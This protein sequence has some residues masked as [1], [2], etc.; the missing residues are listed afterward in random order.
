MHV[1]SRLA[2][3]AAIASLAAFPAHA[4]DITVGGTIN[5]LMMFKLLKETPV[6]RDYCARITARP[7]F[8]RAMERD[9][10]K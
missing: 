7:A 1:F 9:A 10:Q 2:A 3:A 5:F 8:K 4:A 6:L